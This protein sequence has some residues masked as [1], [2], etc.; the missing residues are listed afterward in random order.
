MNNNQ[1]NDYFSRSIHKI[2]ADVLTNTFS[3][4][5]ETAFLLKN[6]AYTKTAAQY[7][8]NY[9][10]Q[11]KHIPA[12]LIS[13]I[14]HSCNLFCTGC[15]A[16][17][18]GNCHDD[19]NKRPMLS[20][21]EWLNIFKQ[22]KNLGIMFNLLAGGEPLIRYEIIEAASQVPEII[23]PIFTNGTLI[24]EKYIKLFNR[25]RNL[26]PIISIEGSP[27][28]T[29]ARRG[30]GLYEKIL[31]VMG[32]LKKNKILFGV[33]VTVTTENLKEVTEKKFTETLQQLGCRAILF[34]EYVP[35]DPSTQNL[36][37]SARERLYLEQSQNKLRDNY[38][39]I[40]FLSFPGDE[41]KMGGCLAAGRGFFH[42]NCYGDAEA[43]PFSPYS[44]CNL[45]NH[46]L[47][48]ALDSPFF[49]RLQD[50]NLVGSIHIGG[51]ALFEKEKQVRE[52]LNKT[53]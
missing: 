23:F 37:F 48:E 17:G 4:P 25:H 14:T 32:E 7:R 10:Q 51:C 42:I 44:D 38:S 31:N 24:D 27:E 16:R 2:I 34:I 52:L 47:L 33:S 29:D 53:I 19:E 46:S 45:Q 1:L 6:L 12:F 39:S 35:V 11:G 5:K 36:A 21:D 22:A 26:F 40:L 18:N 41:N 8:N 30:Q 9:E 50:N 49:H 28:S 13:S 3:N 43:C 20:A 15:Y